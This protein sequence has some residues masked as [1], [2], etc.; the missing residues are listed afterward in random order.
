VTEYW[1][2]VSP[3]NIYIFAYTPELVRTLEAGELYKKSL[4]MQIYFLARA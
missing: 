3:P 4:E 2:V 1:V